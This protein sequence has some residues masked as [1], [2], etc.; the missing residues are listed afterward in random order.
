MSYKQ[1]WNEQNSD[2]A[3]LVKMA[4][5]HSYTHDNQVVIVR[6]NETGE[7]SVEY[8]E[9]GDTSI[10]VERYQVIARFDRRN[11]SLTRSWRI[12]LRNDEKMRDPVEELMSILQL[13]EN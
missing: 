5:R 4:I 10:Y 3:K 1:Y 11:Y 6:D 2:N 8:R 7:L 9:H 13:L 12:I